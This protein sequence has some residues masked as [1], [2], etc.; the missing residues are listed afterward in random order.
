MELNPKIAAFFVT[1]LATFAIQ[2]AEPAA[3]AVVR[4]PFYSA[5]VRASGTNG[6]IAMKGIVVTVGK[7][8]K[9]FMC[10]D[11]DLLRVSMAWTGEFL[12]FGDTLNKIAW[13]PPPQVKGTPAFGVQAGPGWASNGSLSDPRAD[14]QGPLPKSW[15]HYEGLYQYGN[16]VVLSYTVGNAGVLELPGYE[17]G[18][19]TRLIQFT[20]GARNQRLVLLDGVEPVQV[21]PLKAQGPI[22]V[23]LPGGKKIRVSGTNLPE[24]ARFDVTP[25][26]RLVLNLP[27]ISANK[28]F[29]IAFSMSASTESST[30]LGR[31]RPGDLRPWT[32][33]GPVLWTEN[34]VTK[35]SRGTGDDAYVV[36]TI[37]EPLENPW[38]VKTFF[39]G[40]DFFPD[41]RAAI[42]T[43]HGEVFIVSGL[44]D[45]LEKVTWKRYASGLFQP[46]G[47]KVVK[48]HVYVLGRD[49]I[50][51]LH[52]LNKDGEADFYENFNNDTVVTPNYHEFC[53]DL[54]TDRAGN[55][56]FAKGAPW[57]PE[58]TSPHQGCLLKVSKDGS[59][60]EVVATGFRAPNGMTIGPK[61]EITV[62]DNQGH[63]MPSS[64][65]NWIEQGGFYGMTPSAQRIL[66][67]QRGGTNFMA[68]PSDAKAREEFKFKG[69]ESESPIPTGY[70][71]PMAWLPQSM[72]N[73]S[74]GQVWATSRKW[75][76]LN[77]RLL[78]MSYGK[79]TLFEVMPETVDGT[80]QAAMVQLP[81]KFQSGLMR[82]RVNPRDGQVYLSGLRGWQTSATRDGGFYRVRYTGAPARLASEFHAAKNGVTIGFTT[83]LSAK[84]AAD[85]GSYSVERWNYL[86]SGAYGSPEYSVKNPGE[87]KHDTLEVK[88]ARLLPDGKSVWLEIADLTPA[89]QLKIRFSIDAADGTAISQEIYGTIHKLGAAKN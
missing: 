28:P 59:K 88:S 12:D 56:Y 35:G 70:D 46:L 76:P 60:M 68:N 18:Q 79:C 11:A 71:E 44:D 53:L 15:A 74:G 86:W 45:S 55:F 17:M 36:D 34:V 48:N 67:L 25:E 27:K 7:D 22:S 66:T 8:Q 14:G 51:R 24:N 3:N 33:G 57:P 77:D 54:H 29:Q 30:A 81:L 72:D 84:T 64:K 50:T 49:Q 80:R 52:D 5:T 69:W 63:W 73:S 19:F 61:D 9:A 87:K 37:T 13:P 41:G 26:G 47:V 23:S 20:K 10:Y 32:K 21:N 42:C 39:G 85:P 89:D 65:L 83:P 75:G 58:V 40:F 6:T 38:N 78:F 16:R 31:D 4:G 2:A 43:F 1:L 62:S 82:G